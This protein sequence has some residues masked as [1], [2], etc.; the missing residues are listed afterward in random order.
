MVGQYATQ[1]GPIGAGLVIG[2]ITTII[3]YSVISKQ[4]QN[5][6]TTAGAVKG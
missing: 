3:I 1:W 6:L 4:V 2:T 5:S